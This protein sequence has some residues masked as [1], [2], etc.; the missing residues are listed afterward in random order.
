M[1]GWF[2]GPVDLGPT[3]VVAVAGPPSVSLGAA[4]LG[5]RIRPSPATAMAAHYRPGRIRRLP[6]LIPVAVSP[7]MAPGVAVV[8]AP[9]FFPSGAWILLHAGPVRG[10][11]APGGRPGVPSDDGEQTASRW[12]R[13]MRLAAPS[14]ADPS[15]SRAQARTSRIISAARRASSGSGPR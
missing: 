11:Y 1:T 6:A 2:T 3:R 9:T 7:G 5:P 10:H 13:K 15:A 4:M 8:I 12:R 14:R